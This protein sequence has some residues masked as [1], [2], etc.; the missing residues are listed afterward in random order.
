MTTLAAT[1]GDDWEYEATILDE[2]GDPFDL[3]GA[4][5]WFTLKRDR[6]QDDAD[7]PVTLY[8]VSAGASDGIAVA[9]EST[10]VATISMT[11]A[12]TDDLTLPT[13]LWDIQVRSAGK[14]T[15]VASGTMSV[16]A[17]VTRRQ[18]AP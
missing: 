16:E 12:Q 15:T 7:A 2:Q 9:D 10:G 14:T 11:A 5:A 6:E 4:T 18:T 1:R 17:D 8:W 13:Y 3:T